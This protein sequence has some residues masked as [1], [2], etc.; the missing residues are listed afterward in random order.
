[1]ECEDAFNLAKKRLSRD[2]MLYHPDPNKPWIIE[3]DTSKTAF[4]GVLLQPYIV[5]GVTQEV[6]IMFISYSFTG[7]QQSWSTT[8]RELYAIHTSVQKL[9]YM[10]NGGKI[11]I[12][13]DHK[14]LID[15]AAGTAKV[16][17]QQLPK[18]SATGHM[19]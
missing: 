4:T 11:T 10:I 9:H 18:N 15:I 16:Q 8:E 6:A 19:T 14:P 2:P 1:M 3:I 7:M 12:R 5:D 17:N 13:T